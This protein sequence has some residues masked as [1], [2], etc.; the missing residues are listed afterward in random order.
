MPSHALCANRL[1]AT[2]TPGDDIT[3]TPSDWSAETSF[4]TVFPVTVLSADSL[5]RIPAEAS[6][7]TPPS[8]IRRIVRFRTALRGVLRN[9]T[10]LEKKSVMT[11]FWI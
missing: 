4:I 6:P 8:P 9:A 3:S 10:P 2:R 1:C 11:P 7:S 5:T